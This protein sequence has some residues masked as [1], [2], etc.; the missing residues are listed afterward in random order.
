[1]LI[2]DQNGILVY[3]HANN[4]Y[5]GFFS[6]TVLEIAEIQQILEKLL[7]EYKITDIHE[8]V[9]DVTHWKSFFRLSVNQLSIN[10]LK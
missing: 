1:M 9:H 6:K 4:T 5:G 3:L 2:F 7:P 10:N 8:P